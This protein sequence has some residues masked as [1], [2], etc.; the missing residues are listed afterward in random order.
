[1][2]TE[3]Q[4]QT[5]AA[6]VD[7]FV[8]TVPPPNG[9]ADPHGFWATPGTAV[10]AHLA[11]EEYLTTQVPAELRAGLLQLVDAFGLI[12]LQDQ[13]QHLR[14]SSVGEVERAAPEAAVAVNA[15]RQ[16]A[17]NFAYALTDE[18]GH[19]PLLTGMGFPGVPDVPDR[20][21]PTLTVR[22][23]SAGETITCDAV[24]VG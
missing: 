14:E 22:A 24:V 16:L 4:R 7:T 19:S 5:L 20:A 10:G 2:L 18:A 9:S 11:V 3:L 23:T 21:G 6:L 12:G 15:L 8:A 1:M 13:P 17:V